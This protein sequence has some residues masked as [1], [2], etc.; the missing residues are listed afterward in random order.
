MAGSGCSLLA[1]VLTA[2]SGYT[3]LA[4]ALSSLGP[5]HLHTS[6]IHFHGPAS[7]LEN[8]PQQQT[9]E[10]KSGK[11]FQWG[12]SSVPQPHSFGKGTLGMVQT[13]ETEAGANT[14]FPTFPVSQMFEHKIFIKNTP[15][16]K[17]AVQWQGAC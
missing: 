11:S 1:V 15:R 12:L 13:Q 10:E 6:C 2:G 9:S 3:P 16:N 17:V 7:F 5:Q 4:G 14:E 8:D